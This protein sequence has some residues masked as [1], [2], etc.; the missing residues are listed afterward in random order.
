MAEAVLDSSALLAVILAET[1]GD[2]VSSALPEAVIGAINYGE[3]ATKLLEMGVPETEMRDLLRRSECEVLDATAGQAIQAALLRASTR[4]R[5]LSLGDRFC[6]ALAQDLGLPV[7]TA[8]RA[9]AELDVG[10]EITLIR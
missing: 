4:H 9:W 8:D 3:V 6:L 2:K 5:G 1:G 7:L 10:V